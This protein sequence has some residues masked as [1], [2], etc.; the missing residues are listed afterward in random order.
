M[1][2]LSDVIRNGET[3]LEQGGQ[4]AADSTTEPQNGDGE[5][6]EAQF[7]V[8]QQPAP[9]PEA[10]PL[11]QPG[12]TPARHRDEVA[13]AQPAEVTHPPP[14]TTA[15]SASEEEADSIYS[16]L[17]NFVQ[18]VMQAAQAGD[19]FA[20]DQSFVTISR[21]VDMP[22]ATD[23]LYR[24]AIYTR[25]SADQH[26]FE[27]A[28][29]LHSVNVA[30]YAVKIGEGLGYNRDQLIDLGVA[31]LMHD[32]G[33]VTLPPDIFS[34]GQLTDADKQALNQHPL[35]GN[36][37]LRQQGDSF[38]WVSDVALQEHEREDGSGYP[39]GLKGNAIHQYA[40]I[41]G[42]ADMYAGLTRSRPERRGLL[43]FEAVKEILQTHKTKFDPRMIRV[44]LG[45]LSAFPVGSL[46]QL[47]S[48]AVGT[49]VETDEAYPLRPSI[50]IL[51]N[52]QNRRIDDDRIISLREY[53]ILHIVR[54]S[55]EPRVGALR[56][57]FSKQSAEGTEKPDVGE[58]EGEESGSLSGIVQVLLWIFLVLFLAVGVLWQL[59]LIRPTAGPSD[60]EETLESKN[61]ENHFKSLPPAR[62]ESPV[63]PLS[64]VAP[65]SR[66]KASGEYEAIKAA[67]PEKEYKV[68]ANV[69]SIPP[70]LAEMRYALHL[71]SHKSKTSAT[72]DARRLE[73]LKF[74]VHLK[75]VHI[76]KRGWF[77][78]VLAGEYE[79][80]KM[81]LAGMAHLRST[82]YAEYAA[83]VKR[84]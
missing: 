81:A 20:I 39:N 47:N 78:R 77:Y 64:P 51:Y 19:P 75:R 23:L 34:K 6:G 7:L 55:L 42:L 29:V 25:E 22:Q 46:V 24:K 36:E 27:S 45:K 26:A 2:R 10:G 62:T 65:P 35:K 9:T 71:S 32:V 76:P 3:A 74:K 57:R 28:V 79:T 50:R 54:A 40:K 83:I 70:V 59:G 68:E 49:V 53:P 82:G 12:T 66:T 13:P 56:Q 15:E 69:Q 72:R 14:V 1:A 21:A 30:I 73:R 5:G 44:L 8:T 17:F 52:A 38:D 16:Q 80:K 41:V 37:I 84:R 43:P 31:A 61:L 18:G 48:G 11:T 33:M 4:Q 67:V 63:T 58:A 60:I